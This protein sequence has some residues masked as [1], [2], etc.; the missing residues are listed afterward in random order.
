MQMLPQVALRMIELCEIPSPSRD[1]AAIAGAVIPQLVALGADVRQDD[2]ATVIGAGCNNITARFAPT[3]AGGTPLAFVAHL[4]TVPPTD[5]IEVEL[6]GEVLTNRHPTILGADNKAAIAAFMTAIETIIHEGRPHSGIELV[7]T[8]CEEIGLLGAAALDPESL[9]A[10]MAVVYDHTG[11]IG[12]VIQSSPSLSSLE[13]TFVGRPAHAG[14][15]P[16]QGRSA[17]VAASRAVASM[18]HGRIDSE[19]TANVG[20]VTG[21]TATNVVAERAHVTAEARSRNEGALAAQLTAMLDALTLAASETEVDLETRV[22]RVFTG[23]SLAP[24]DP[25]VRLAS[26]ALERVGVRPRLVPSGGGSDVNAL[27]RNGLPSVN[28]CNAMRAVH[29]DE[30]DIRV[31]D[32]STMV[33]VTLAIVDEARSD[34]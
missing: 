32:L 12:D 10:R 28:L 7:L 23:Y 17:L 9:D 30:E 3:T 19:T 15:D 4:D 34:W 2:A 16:E 13:A 26:A 21:G 31:D 14:I 8:P 20:T 5:R 27:I 18:P 22:E 6:V 29:T 1:E 33:D 25:Q 11:P 24:D